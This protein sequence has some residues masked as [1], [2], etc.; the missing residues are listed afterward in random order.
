MANKN[1]KYLL[2]E[3]YKLCPDGICDLSVLTEQ[4]QQLQ[5][6]GKGMF[7]SGIFQRG[8]ALN[9]NGRV[10]PTEVLARE[11]ERYQQL[12]NENRAYGSLDHPENSIIELKNACCLVR[13]LWWE[14][15]D[16]WGKIQILSTPDGNIIR[17]IIN[18]GGTIGVSS[19]GL[20]SVREEQGKTFVNEDFNLVAFDL[21]GDPS[22]VGAFLTVN[23]ARQRN[24][25]PPVDKSAI[26]T[27]RLNKI[28]SR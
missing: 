9:Q 15:N 14:G 27:E 22:T 7:L 6:S 24:L 16:L 28:L 1:E 23:E 12:V 2:R 26:I 17:S 8:N 18:D 19:R 11:V 13:K 5:K 21:V 20:G 25:L 10:Y 4:E 3:F